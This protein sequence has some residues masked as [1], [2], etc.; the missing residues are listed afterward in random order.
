MQLKLNLL[1]LTTLDTVLQ[2]QTVIMGYDIYTGEYVG[3][4]IVE[5]FKIAVDCY[6]GEVKTISSV[7][8]FFI[9]TL[10]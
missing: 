2:D 7:K 9:I 1:N 3:D 4:P 6:Y 8:I 5:G 10:F